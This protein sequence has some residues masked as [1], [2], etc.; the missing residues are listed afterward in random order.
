MVISLRWGKD[1]DW[2]QNQSRATQIKLLADHRLSLESAEEQKARIEKIKANK[3]RA[4]M[5]NW[6]DEQSN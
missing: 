6:Q 1:P 4:M 5:E 3:L 2:F